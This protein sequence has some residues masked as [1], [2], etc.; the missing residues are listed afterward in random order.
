MSKPLISVIMTAY[1]A[2]EFIEKSIR[3]VLEQTYQNLQ[4]IIINDG[5][6]D[7]TGQIVRKFNDPRIE[8]FELPENRHIA[9]A[10]N[11]GFSKVRGDYIAII[12]SDDIW[13]PNKLEKQI[14]YLRSN[15]QHQGCFTWVTLIDENG[16]VIDDKMPELQ[17]QFSAHTE[18]REYWLRFFFFY[19]NRLNN[20]SSLIT[21]ESLAEIGSHNLFYIQAMDFEWWVRFT[22]KFSFGILEEPLVY[23]RRVSDPKVNVSSCSEEHDTRFYN[24]YM[25]IRH[26]FFDDMDDDLFIRTFKDF[27]VYPD[28]KSSQE[29]LCEKAFL[30][31]RPIQWS[32]WPSPLGLFP[33]EKLMEDRKLSDLLKNTYH[34]STIECGKYTKIHLFNDTFTRKY[35]EQLAQQRQHLDMAYQKIHQKKKILEA[36]QEQNAQ[37]DAQILQLKQELSETDRRRQAV[38]HDLDV[39]INSKSWKLTAPV[40][41]IKDLLS[42]WKK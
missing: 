28:S 35:P 2:E 4:L 39:I 21:R 20:P 33:L 9:Y 12:D 26:R 42:R 34:Y 22:K 30:L 18:S 5:S 1:N 25:C 19:G 16:A 6:N 7:L 10:T 32:S 36:C 3:S 31:C 37:K 14:C 27:F 8:Y 29:L 17:E 13:F 38:Q 40:R 41:N 23:Y 15:P 11:I 24:E